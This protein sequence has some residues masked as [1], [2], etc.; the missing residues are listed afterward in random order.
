MASG[1]DQYEYM[2]T[3]REMEDI[4]RQCARLVNES[5]ETATETSRELHR[6]QESLDRSNR[7][8]DR[9]DDDLTQSKRSMR[10]INSPFGGL[11]N[12]FAR[13]NKKGKQKGANPPSSKSTR[14][15][16]RYHQ[17]SSSG[18]SLSQYPSTGNEVVDDNLDEVARGLADM[19]RVG[20]EIGHQLDHSMVTIDGLH[21]KVTDR[22]DKLI[23]LNKKIGKKIR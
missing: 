6:Q 3:Q 14:S 10:V 8:L 21:S 17:S 9:M 13:D 5:L 15:D 2:S 16:E 11:R 7:L 12:Y 19:K 18:S 4:S 22:D 1:S 23:H 20:L